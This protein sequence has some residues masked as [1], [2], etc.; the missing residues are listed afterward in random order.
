M[1][2][3]HPDRRRLSVYNQPARLLWRSL[4]AGD[5]ACLPH[6]LVSRYGLPLEAAQRDVDAILAQWIE[7]GLV[8]V[9]DDRPR[10]AIETPTAE[11][12]DISPSKKTEAYRFAN[13][14]VAL[15]AQASLL[16]RI[17]P[18]LAHLRI[19]DAKPNPC[20]DLA[21]VIGQTGADRYFIAVDGRVTV[22]DVEEHVVI[23]AFHQTVIERLYPGAQWRAFMHA[24]AVARDNAVAIF[25]AP[26]GSGKS[27]LTASLVARGYDYF[28]DDMV[29]L[30]AQG[31]AVA[32]FPLP[33]SVKPGAARVLSRCYPSLDGFEA[34]KLQYLFHATPFAARPAPARALIFPRY[35]R[36]APTRF[37]SLSVTEALTR[38]MSDRVYLGYP[39]E[40]AA[41]RGFALWLGR[42]GRYELV[43]SD[44]EEADRCVSQALTR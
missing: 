40:P 21:C 15:S 4:R 20:P 22:D 35:V 12:T 2:L 42:V 8:V 31:D 34:S 29:P 19:A 43:Y 32:P 28:S 1:V 30:M 38:L 17:A 44:I 24:A 6:I 11:I 16:G 23:G 33:T 13:L 36:G 5:A 7:Q 18:L 41:V 26:S 9:G 37:E 3:L 27:T 39:I 10:P 25:A 14:V